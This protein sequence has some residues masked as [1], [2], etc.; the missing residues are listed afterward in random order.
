MTATKP[1]REVVR[2]RV[3]PDT[4]RAEL[5]ETIAH[6]KA[7][8]DRLPIHWVE[9]RAVFDDDIDELVAEWLALQV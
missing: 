6:V 1:E 7:R 8:R 2:I 3:T 9:K 5:A 4:T